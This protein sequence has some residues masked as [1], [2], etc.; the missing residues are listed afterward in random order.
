MY[1]L[2]ILASK[3]LIHPINIPTSKIYPLGICTFPP[4]Q[5]GI[6]FG[7]LAVQ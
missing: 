4:P 3:K 7:V 6:T 5:V 2:K 1:K